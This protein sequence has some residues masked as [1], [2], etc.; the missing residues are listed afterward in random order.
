MSFE[1]KLRRRMT[2][3]FPSKMIDAMQLGL[4]VVAWGPEYCSAVEWARRGQRA[5]SVSDPNPL[6]LRQALEQLAALPAEQERLAKSA[7]DAAAGEFSCKRIQAQFIDAL[8]R[9]IG[10]RHASIA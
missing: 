8:K 6:A 10:S 1:A 2:T 3:S 4:P 9:A 7:R 5:L